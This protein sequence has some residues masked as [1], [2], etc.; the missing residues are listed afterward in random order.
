M[1]P[2]ASNNHHQT[3]FT[4]VELLIVIVVIGI[5]AAITIVSYNGIQG[6][7]QDSR[8]VSDV[9]N[10]RDAL[11]LYKIQNN[12]FP[13][14]TSANTD[15]SGWE[16]SYKNNSFIPALRTSGVLNADLLDPINND[17]YFYRYYKYAAA[18][19]SCDPAK[20][21]YFVLQIKLLQG[22]TALGAGPGFDCPGRNWTT[23]AAWTAGGYLN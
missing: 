21:E 17:T 7:A 6:R 19:Y 15:S 20:G 13:A 22:T 11:E 4:I 8:R 1:K 9:T 23:S 5:L 14:V 3:G 16:V 12:A 10:L 2:W 18:Q